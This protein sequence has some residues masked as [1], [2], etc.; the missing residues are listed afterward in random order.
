M[1]YLQQVIVFLILL[2]KN[3]QCGHLDKD[4]V[5]LYLPENLVMFIHIIQRHYLQCQQQV[6]KMLFEELQIMSAKKFS[7]E[8]EEFVKRT[9]VSYLDAVLEYCSQNKIEP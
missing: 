5:G 2:K 6:D 3:T 7:Y 1:M 4:F 8:I 9:G